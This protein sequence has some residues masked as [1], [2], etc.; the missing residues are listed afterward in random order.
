MTGACVRWGHGRLP[1]VP[2]HRRRPLPRQPD[3]ARRQPKRAGRRARHP[4]R[5]R[6]PGAARLPHGRLGRR[7]PRGRGR[8]LARDRL[9]RGVRRA[10]LR[11]PPRPLVPGAPPEPW[12]A[13]GAVAGDAPARPG[14]RGPARAGVRPARRTGRR[15]RVRRRSWPASTTSRSA[16]ARHPFL[17][18]PLLPLPGADPEA[19]TGGGQRMLSRLLDALMARRDIPD[20]LLAAGPSAP[21]PPGSARWAS[22]S[23]ISSAPAPRRPRRAG[24]EPPGLSG[25]FADDELDAMERAASRVPGPPPADRGRVAGGGRRRPRRGWGW[26]YP[27]HMS[28]RARHRSAPTSRSRHR[29]PH[30]HPPAALA[31]RRT[32]P[33]PRS[34]AGPAVQRRHGTAHGT[35]TGRRLTRR[36]PTAPPST[37]AARVDGAGGRTR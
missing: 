9:R 5:P 18:R 11:P 19:P 23:T 13:R 3:R 14:R 21:P 22:A 31:R 10:R 12:R 25:I 1:A 8:P 35:G 16:R 4:F 24:A 17:E 28:E 27:G 20:G 15:R 32:A 37:T 30:R 7:R 6:Q 2:E 36:R 26:S 34:R 29:A 33:R